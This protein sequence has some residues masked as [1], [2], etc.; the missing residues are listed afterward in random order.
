MRNRFWQQRIP[1]I[2]AVLFIALGVFATSYLTQ[3]T[4]VFRGLASPSEDPKNIRIT[5]V[6]DSSFTI[7]YVTDSA[8]TG[9]VVY[10]NSQNLSSV[11]TDD[12]DSQKAIAQHSLH[13]M[14]LKNLSP[15]TKYFFSIVS[16]QTTYSQS[17]SD[18]SA[19]KDVA[20]KPFE[21]TTGPLLNPPSVNR[22]L[23]G[24][25]IGVDGSIPKEA[26]VFLKSDDSQI[27]SALIDNNGLYSFPIG[28]LRTLDL[29]SYINTEGKTFTINVQ[30]NNVSSTAVISSDQ[31]E[32]PKIILSD[33]YDYTVSNLPLATSTASLGFPN[34]L[35]T[36]SATEPGITN[37]KED[38]KL[39]DQQ[40]L[41]KG[42]AL[43]GSSIQI[44]IHSSVQIQKTVTAD[45]KGSW[46]YRPETP[47][48][49][50][51][52]TITIKTQD[53]FGIIRSI[54]QSFTVFAEGSQVEQP[55]TP[56]ANPTFVPTILPPTPTP[57]VIV[58]PSNPPPSP[59]PTSGDSSGI[60]TGLIAISSTLVGLILLIFTRGKI[61]L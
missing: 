57:T 42:T 50:G 19:T 61:P 26:I 40:P 55:A 30:G 24:S 4:A 44:T 56:S 16:G 37:P 14:T 10:G 33:N 38:Q 54:T 20:A 2:F 23:N 28:S 29:T 48:D 41:F 43:P 3:N 34:L 12:R 8:Q 52:H 11:A 9:S 51:N 58:I 22:T 45:Q 32:V 21:V 60:K 7:S 36:S 59:V 27:V 35:A 6:T 46:S 49:P 15:S 17:E 5:N 47:L 18:T 39:T 25:I 53:K 1:T 13:I 31:K